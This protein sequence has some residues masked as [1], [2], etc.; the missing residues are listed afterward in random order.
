MLARQACIRPANLLLIRTTGK[1]GASRRG[2]RYLRPTKRLDSMHYVNC[3]KIAR[4]G[5][6]LLVVIF[7]FGTLLI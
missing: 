4:Q 7:N 3:V 5:T 1:D 2:V 6:M